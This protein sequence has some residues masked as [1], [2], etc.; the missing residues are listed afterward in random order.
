MVPGKYAVEKYH[1]LKHVP[2]YASD[3]QEV[4]KQ[5]LFELNEPVDVV[6]AEMVSYVEFNSLC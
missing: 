5:E 1:W 4:R 2:F 6:R 3:L